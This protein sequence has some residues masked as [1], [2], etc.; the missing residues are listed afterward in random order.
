MEQTVEEPVKRAVREMAID[1]PVEVMVNNDRMWSRMERL[2]LGDTRTQSRTGIRYQ[3]RHHG[4][5]HY[6]LHSGKPNLG[7]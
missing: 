4:H 5:P 1:K 7:G 3:Q 6:L 2:G